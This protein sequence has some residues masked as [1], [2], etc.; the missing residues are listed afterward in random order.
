MEAVALSMFAFVGTAEGL[1]FLKTA[2]E[3]AAA[4]VASTGLSATAE[5]LL[6]PRTA[7]T[8]QASQECVD[9]IRNDGVH[10]EKRV[11][12]SGKFAGTMEA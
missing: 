1:F 10:D 7:R 9:V 12:V 2:L 5:N 8:S 11:S 6:T 3:S 4:C